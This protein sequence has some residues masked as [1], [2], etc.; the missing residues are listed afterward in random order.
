MNLKTLFFPISLAIALLVFIS[1]IK[2]EWDEYKMGSSELVE[3]N[4]EKRGVENS[5]SKIR[6][7]NEDMNSQG[8]ETTKLI[9]NFLPQ[10]KGDDDLVAEINKNGERSGILIT[11]VSLGHKRDTKKTDCEKTQ[12]SEN[13]KSSYCPSPLNEYEIKLRAQ[14]LY[15]NLK[16]FIGMLDKQNRLFNPKSVS[17]SSGRITDEEGAEIIS[18]ELELVLE[19]SYFSREADNGL[20]MS[21]ISVSDPIF[22]SLLEKGLDIDAIDKFKKIVTS[23]YF[24]PVPYE[25]A[26]KINPFS[27]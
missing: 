6:K 1:Y 23:E 22:K 17:I 4:E 26:G 27:N 15:L 3:L 14:G 9:N 21:K 10:A 24:S 7:A 19:G 8:E 5:A 25:G 20:E 12:T 2:P 16:N 18:E 13:D 11:A